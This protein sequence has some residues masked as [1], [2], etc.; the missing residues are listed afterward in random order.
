MSRKVILKSDSEPAHPANFAAYFAMSGSVIAAVRIT[1][2]TG[3]RL[4]THP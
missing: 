2:K 3:I 1:S 4:L